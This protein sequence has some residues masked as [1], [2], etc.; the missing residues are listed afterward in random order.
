MTFWYLL[1]YISDDIRADSGN[2]E[3][4][5]LLNQLPHSL[6]A[7]SATDTSKVYSTPSTKI[8]VDPWKYLPRSNEWPISNV[9]FQG[10]KPIIEDYKTQGFIIPCA[11]TCN[12]PL[13]MMRKTQGLVLGPWAVTNIVIPQQPIV[14][15]PHV[16]PTSVST[17]SK[18]F[19]VTDLCSAFI[20]IPVDEASQYLLPSLEK[21]TKLPG[22][23]Y[24]RVLLRYFLFLTNPEDWTPNIKLPRV[25]L[26]Q[27]CGPFVSL[28][29][30]S[31]F[32]VGRQHPLAKAF[33]NI[34]SLQKN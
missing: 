1:C 24:L 26:C 29:F 30:F 15:N 33:R 31:R 5:S 32:L 2:R 28:L 4:L 23:K 17:R 20:S 27:I 6:Q 3:H 12:T 11:R 22:Q 7:K 10:I 19:I 34:G 21:K 13:L 25:L 9:T 18:F 16:P 8:Q 14:S